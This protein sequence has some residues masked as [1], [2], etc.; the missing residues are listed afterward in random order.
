M[1]ISDSVYCRS[2]SR[3]ND[4]VA[5]LGRQL[6]DLL[7]AELDVHQ[8]AHDLRIAPEA[9]AVGMIG[10]Q[11]HLPRVLD[12]QQQLQPDGPLHGVDQIAIACRRRERCR[13]R[14]RSRRR[15]CPTCGRS[16]RRASAARGRRR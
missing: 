3:E 2:M 4:A 14:F 16:A 1:A 11:K 5:R 8:Q 12:E 10:R 15:G 9:A 7:L 6:R 13:S